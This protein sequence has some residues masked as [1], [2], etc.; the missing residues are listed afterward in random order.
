MSYDEYDR[1]MGVRWTNLQ[2][3]AASPAAY[4][5]QVLRGRGDTAS[6]RVGR[7]VHCALLEPASYPD[8]WV[9]WTG[10]Q[11]RGPKWDQ[12]RKEH[13]GKGV[14]SR[15]ESE[16]VIQ[17]SSAVKRHK[18]ARR[19]LDG[20]TLESV[21]IWWDPETGILCK[22][23]SDI[24]HHPVGLTKGKYVEL[25]TTQATVEPRAFGRLAARMGYISGMAFHLD[26]MRAAGAG[27]DDQPYIIAVEA[28]PPY[29]CVV[30]LVGEA[31]IEA[32][33]NQYRRLLG[34]V[35][36]CAKNDANGSADAWPGCAP[37]HVV[38]LE[39]P[40]WAYADPD[41]GYMGLDLTGLEEVG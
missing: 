25:K 34:R 24:M 3:M 27:V 40:E 31:L 12:F 22:C 10:T 38:P 7:A 30:F 17:T 28:K 33:R 20:S 6:R 14:L 2:K 26:G 37:D 32:G 16:H 41:A 19:Y 13:V 11:K 4:L 9:T 8:R 29:D 23:R 15:V 1:Q 39:L 35:A 18:V 21:A 36:E 5:E